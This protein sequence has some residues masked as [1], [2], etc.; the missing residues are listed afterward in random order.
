MT[1]SYNENGSIN[2]IDMTGAIPTGVFIS[3]L[4][5]NVVVTVCKTA[6]VVVLSF[7]TSAST[8]FARN[9]SVVLS[10]KKK[11]RVNTAN[12]YEYYVLRSNVSF[13]QFCDLC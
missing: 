4:S 7:F 1:Y 11:S 2:N 3:I 9:A 13:V 12:K 6:D 5:E 8:F 10:P